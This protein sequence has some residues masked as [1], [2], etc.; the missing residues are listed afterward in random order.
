MVSRGYKGLNAE[1][2]DNFG[3]SSVSI[4]GDTMAVGVTQEDSR[5]SVTMELS[6]DNN[7]CSGSS[8]L[9]LPDIQVKLGSGGLHKGINADAND[10]FGYSVDQMRYS[11][12]GA[13]HEDSCKTPSQTALHQV[14]M[15]LVKTRVLYMFTEMA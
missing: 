1:T 14:T 6:S 8:N 7:S 2:G 13:T 11:A 15:T 9:C 4:F 10:R 5:R 12:V 3:G